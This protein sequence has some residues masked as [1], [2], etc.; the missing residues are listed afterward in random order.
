MRHSITEQEGLAEVASGVEECP[1]HLLSPPI[2]IPREP[3]LA[4]PQRA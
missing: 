3:K 2:T 4:K 1:F